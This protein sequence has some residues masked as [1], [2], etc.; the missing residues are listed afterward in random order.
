SFEGEI[1]YDDPFIPAMKKFIRN[2]KFAKIY[3]VD[4]ITNKAEYCMYMITSFD[5]E[6]GHGDLAT[7]SVE[8][9]LFGSFCETELTEIQEGALGIERLDCNR[10]EKEGG[11]VEG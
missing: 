6:Y 5:R 4:L 7:Y 9:N 10:N 1:V 2:K 3:E 8:A 11:K